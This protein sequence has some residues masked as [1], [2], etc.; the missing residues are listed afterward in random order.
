MKE[1]EGKKELLSEKPS[2]EA[3]LSKKDLLKENL[4]KEV[5]HLQKFRPGQEKIIDAII[6]GRDTFAIL[7]TGGGKSLC[8][9]LSGLY[10]SLKKSGSGVIV[11]ISPLISLMHDQVYKLK[12]LGIE[13]E[14]LDSNVNKRKAAEILQKVKGREKGA[15]A[16]KLSSSVLRFLYLSPEKLQ[17][18]RVRKAFSENPPVLIA[19][20]EAHCISQWGHDFR[21]AYGKIKNFIELF[22]ER[23]V[24]AAFTATA[25]KRVRQDIVKSLALRKAAVFIGSFDRPNLYWKNIYTVNKERK[26]MELLERE[27][28][29]SGI[30]YCST[31]VET[32]RLTGFLKNKGVSVVRYHGKMLAGERSRNAQAFVDGKIKV[33]VATSAFGLGV[34][35]P[36]TRFVINFNLPLSVEEYYQEAGRAGRDGKAA[37]CILLYNKKDYHVNMHLIAESFKFNTERK[38]SADAFRKEENFIQQRISENLLKMMWRYAEHEGCLRNF[39]LSYFGEARNVPCGRCC[40]CL[41]NEKNTLEKIKI[42]LSENLQKVLNL[43]LKT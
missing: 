42:K 16:D 1:K 39:L 3:S 11:V 17:N 13:A 8:Y 24:V 12:K 20:D 27:K 10:L 6:S 15:L 26:L 40:N 21:P 14:V 18:K 2:S 38:S 4:L 22:S 23:P 9:Q 7:P 28:G 32:E 37:R 29:N 19:V 31:V 33:I 41:G 34:D 25:T 36:Y 35:F 30:I 43:L 5:F